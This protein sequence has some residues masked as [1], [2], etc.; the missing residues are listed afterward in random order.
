MGREILVKGNVVKTDVFPEGLY[1]YTIKFNISDSQKQLIA[2]VLKNELEVSLINII[3][4]QG[5]FIEQYNQNQWKD[6]NF[7]WWA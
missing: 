1:G 7:E 3:D 2:E 5:C 6:A 4:K